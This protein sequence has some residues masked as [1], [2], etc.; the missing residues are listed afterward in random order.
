MC[1]FS[2]CENGYLNCGLDVECDAKLDC[3]MDDNGVQL[4][5]VN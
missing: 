5:E 3:E 1:V 2:V 4:V